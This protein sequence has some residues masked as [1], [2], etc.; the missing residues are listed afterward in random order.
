[1]FINCTA[2][3]LTP[4]QIEAAKQYSDNIRNLKELNPDLYNQL[5]NCPSN[6]IEL[7]N[8]S[9]TFIQYLLHLGS[10]TGL[11]NSEP[12]EKIVVHLP[13][14]SPF[15]MALFFL[16]FP[17]ENK[18]QFVFSH[19]DRVSIDEKLPDGSITKKAIFKFIRFLEL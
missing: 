13:I 5:V 17:K 14:G 12:N 4:E 19:S 11:P 10:Y 9:E 6:E 15:L 1:M 18:I 8:L 3:N 16:N 2:H 7:F